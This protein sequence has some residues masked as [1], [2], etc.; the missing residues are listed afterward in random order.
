MTYLA[1]KQTVQAEERE[2]ITI[3]FVPPQDPNETKYS[4]EQPLFVFYEQVIL[5]NN[6]STPFTVYAMELVESKTNSGKLLNQPYWKYKI[7]NGE[8]SFWKVE[9]ALERYSDTCAQC[10]HFQDYQESNGRGWCRLFEQAAKT[11]HQ[12]TNDCDLFGD[13]NPLDVPHARFALDSIVKVIDATE[14]HSEWASF[15][16]IGRQYNHELYRSTEAYLSET[17]WYYWLVNPS[18]E[19]TYGERLWV[20]EDQICL[21]DESHLISTEDIF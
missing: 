14:H 9:S 16:I 3:E 17:A 2:L 1:E 5:K 21:F 13:Q 6:S 7:T 11:H 4:C 18:Y 12:R 8:V 19:S 10:S 20:A 15:V